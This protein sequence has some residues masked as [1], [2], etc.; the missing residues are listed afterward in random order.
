MD[1][2]V[3]CLHENGASF[4]KDL[5]MSTFY[6]CLME[7]EPIVE[8]GGI[9]CCIGFVSCLAGAAGDSST[10]TK[11]MDHTI[12][13][14]FGSCFFLCRTMVN[15]HKADNSAM[16]GAYFQVKPCFVS[17]SKSLLSIQ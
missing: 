9:E 17:I 4:V 5:V 15:A 7:S 8:G 1:Y 6:D 12:L 13:T 16:K 10:H 2:T 14:F 3:A 11:I